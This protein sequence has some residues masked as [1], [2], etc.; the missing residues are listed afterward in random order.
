[1]NLIPRLVEQSTALII[2]TAR[3]LEPLYRDAFDRWLKDPVEE[4]TQSLLR[5][6]LKD[7]GLAIAQESVK[8]GEA[9]LTQT[10][11]DTMNRFLTREYRET[12]SVAERAG[13]T[14]T[15]GLVKASFTVNPDLPKSLQVG[16]FKP[17]KRY[18]AYIRF[19]GPGPRV[20]PDVKD[21]GILSIGIKLMG[22]PGK[23]LL[24]DEQFT[25]DF[26]GISSP[27]FTTPTVQENVKLQQQLGRGTPA[28]YFLNPLDSHLLD[29]I[30]QG[31]YARIH[32]NPLALSY[33]S[34]VPYLFG[35]ENGQDRAIKFAVFPS[36]KKVTP[37]DIHDDN[38]L[39]NAMIETLNKQSV[40]FDF[41]IQFQKDPV[42][43]P[44]EDASI[45][46]PEKDSPFIT[47]ASIEIPKQTFTHASQDAFARNLTFNPWHTLAE[48]RPLGNQ[49][50][51]RKSIYLATSR[52]RQS[53][54]AEQHIEPTG[55]EIF[56]PG[57]PDSAAF[58]PA[59]LKTSQA[60]EPQKQTKK[61]RPVN[62]SMH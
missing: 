56:E 17:G 55:D 4:I 27:T 34:C 46:W 7:E 41:A 29:M 44:I 59:T 14:K 43:M 31:L 42:K 20:V 12:K 5:L 35:K 3:R 61:T 39:R 50:R 54:N 21:N 2:G 11:I 53:I 18:P 16:L 24:D 40:S 22:V 51:A 32:A 25:V 48:L 62:E 15:Y 23:K 30:M 37:P 60:R 38:F 45:I 47:V 58:K 13:N 49:N 1:M 36:L 9:K 57:K 52:M 8:P 6:R 28:W 33:Y 26:S 19:G 10:I